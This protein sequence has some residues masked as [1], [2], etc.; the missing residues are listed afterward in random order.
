MHANAN[1]RLTLDGLS[2]PDHWREETA[3]LKFG[4]VY[5]QCY[6]CGGAKVTL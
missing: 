3:R 2:V 4:E 6:F 5:L 1:E